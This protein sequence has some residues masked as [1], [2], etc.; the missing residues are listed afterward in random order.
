MESATCARS[1]KKARP[2][3]RRFNVSPKTLKRWGERGFISR[4]KINSR[5]TLYDERE[6]ETYI[7][8]ARVGGAA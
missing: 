5:V 2:L 3:S 4:F 6:V 1:F 8:S 7:E